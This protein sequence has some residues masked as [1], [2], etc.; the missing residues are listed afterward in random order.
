[1]STTTFVA[2]AEAA[3]FTFG[4]ALIHAQRHR[5]ERLTMILAVGVVLALLG[6]AIVSFPEGGLNAALEMISAADVGSF[7]N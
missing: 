5:A 2:L 4:C 3:A 6:L 7:P 1:M